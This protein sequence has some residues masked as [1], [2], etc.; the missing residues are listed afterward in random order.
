[1]AN[2][3]STVS[4][5]SHATS[6][7]VFNGLNFSEWREQVNFH[8]GVLD[9]DL[10][11]LEEKPT[12]ITDESSDTEKLKLKAWDSQKN[13]RIACLCGSRCF[14]VAIQGGMVAEEGVHYVGGAVG[15]GAGAGVDCHWLCEE[16]DVGVCVVRVVGLERGG[17]LR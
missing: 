9:L 6:V 8:L 5:H 15:A 12:D 14:T 1:M 17:D 10:A 7:T 13:Q 3:A 16:K 2:S 4:L 11:L